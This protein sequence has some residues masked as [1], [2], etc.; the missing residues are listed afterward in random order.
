MDQPANFFS[1][2]DGIDQLRVTDRKSQL[3]PQKITS[4]TNWCCLT[5]VK[6]VGKQYK[7]SKINYYKQY[8]ILF[9]YQ[10]Q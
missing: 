4:S 2:L 1:G 5:F 3:V 9:T 8:Y 6:T 10:V 7:N